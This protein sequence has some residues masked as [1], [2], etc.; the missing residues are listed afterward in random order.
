[1]DVCVLIGW[2]R[3]SGRFGEGKDARWHSGLMERLLEESMQPDALILHHVVGI[4]PKA[5]KLY[6]IMLIW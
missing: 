5:Y 6:Y 4:S 3:S 2:K 1:M